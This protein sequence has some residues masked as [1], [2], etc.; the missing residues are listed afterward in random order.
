MTSQAHSILESL[1]RVPSVTG[2]EGRAAETLAECCELAGL[3]VEM[4]EV[5]PGRPNVIARWGTGR[6]PVVLLTG[7]IDTVPVGSGWTR[8]PFGAEV[9]DGRLYGRGACDMKGGLAAMLAAVADLRQEGLEPD[10][11]VIF[12]A[13][14]G[15]EEDSAG[16]LALVAGALRADCAVLAEPTG[17]ELVRSNRGLVNYSLEIAGRSAHASSP[18]LG[19]NAIVAAARIILELDAIALRLVDQPHPTLGPPNLSVGTIHGGTRPYVVPDR[20]VIE[21]DRRVNPGESAATV[22]AEADAALAGARQHLPWLSASFRLGSEYLPF[23]LAEDHAFVRAMLKAME[24]A[25]VP[26]RLGAWR[27]ASDAGFLS[28]RAQIPC[29]LFGPG[30]ISDAHRPDEFVELKQVELA[31]AV[32][33]RLLHAGH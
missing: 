15:E 19:Q 5:Q 12:A 8:D 18:E 11:D 3:G 9:A 7:H 17:L 26:P 33:R 25:S 24:A 2:S 32:F 14:V 29:V 20:C 30:D 28:A 16:T 31:R 6:S 4:R 21:V 13:V 22:R 10:G 1:I 23:E 27:A